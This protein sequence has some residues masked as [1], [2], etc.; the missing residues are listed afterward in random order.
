M[1]LTWEEIEETD[2]NISWIKTE[3]TKTAYYGQ[4]LPLFQPKVYHGG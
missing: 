1:K 3:R 2:N 4:S